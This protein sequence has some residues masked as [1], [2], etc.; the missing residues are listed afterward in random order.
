MQKHE[1]TFD[2]LA[3]DAPKINSVN[4]SEFSYGDTLIFNGTSLYP[5]IRIPANFNIYVFFEPFVTVSGD[6]TELQLTLDTDRAMFPS[7]HGQPVR[8][9]VVSIYLND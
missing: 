4:Q 5:G 8:K 6:N 1:N 9:T 2:V 3:E 7:Y